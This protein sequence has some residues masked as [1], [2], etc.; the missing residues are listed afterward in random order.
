MTIA[1]VK[2]AQKEARM[3]DAEYRSLLKRLTGKTSSTQLDDAELAIV[4]GALKNAG[5]PLIHKPTTGK[6]WAL[7]YNELAPYLPERERNG[8]Y[9][10]GIVNRVTGANLVSVAGFDLLDAKEAHVAIETLK[11]KANELNPCPF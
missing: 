3:G 1:A 8:A 6:I 10:L 4:Y 5:K 2:I 7:W 9:L 11:A